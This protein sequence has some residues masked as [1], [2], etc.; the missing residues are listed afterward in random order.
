MTFES[1]ELLSF[2]VFVLGISVGLMIG[3]CCTNPST[4]HVTSAS[5]ATA[6]CSTCRT[7]RP[8]EPEGPEG[9]PQVGDCGDA[10]EEMRVVYMAKGSQVF[11]LRPTCCWL[12]RS[13]DVQAIPLCKN[14]AHCAA[15]RA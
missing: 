7:C 14:C 1:Y 5:T 3:R 4:T 13:K 12:S 15:K 11:H 6:T 2:F 8:P 10:L 9:H